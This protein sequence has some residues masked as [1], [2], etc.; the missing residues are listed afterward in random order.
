MYT[1]MHIM[2]M[3]VLK[4]LGTM[5]NESALSLFGFHLGL[6][7]WT[8]RPLARRLDHSTSIVDLFWVG[9]LRYFGWIQDFLTTIRN[10]LY[11]QCGD[12]P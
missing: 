2:L 4:K 12:T 7:H 8:L 3:F 1:Y 9:A 11:L 6:Q 10:F 5:K